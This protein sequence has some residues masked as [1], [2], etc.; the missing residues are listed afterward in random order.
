VDRRVSL[1]IFGRDSFSISYFNVMAFAIWELFLLFLYL[2]LG[3]LG[4]V[5]GGSES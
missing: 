3:L 5:P 1:S 2:I 4:V